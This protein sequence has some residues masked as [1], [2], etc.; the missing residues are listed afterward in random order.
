MQQN[1]G[2]YST[3]VRPRAA[4]WKRLLGRSLQVGAGLLLGLRPQSRQPNCGPSLHHSSIHQPKLSSLNMFEGRG[5]SNFAVA[6]SEE[7]AAP[8][9]DYQL[10]GLNRDHGRTPSEHSAQ[11]SDKVKENA[12]SDEGYSSTS[13]DDLSATD[14]DRRGPRIWSEVKHG[15]VGFPAAEGGKIPKVQEIILTHT[16]SR[17]DRVQCLYGEMWGRENR[18][19]AVVVGYV[20]SIPGRE[21]TENMAGGGEDVRRPCPTAVMINYR[22]L[23]TLLEQVMGTDSM[24]TPCL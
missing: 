12:S 4:R 5:P 7:V 8:M 6:D 14:S 10:S 13:D 3:G 24:P 18:S 9:D 16:Y 22:P 15:E 20:D 1:S 23:V 17:R 2:Y 19:Y 21:D 11:R